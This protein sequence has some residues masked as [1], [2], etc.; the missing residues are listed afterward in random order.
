MSSAFPEMFM[1]F[2]GLRRHS[3]GE[4]DLLDTKPELDPSGYDIGMQGALAVW[5]LWREEIRGCSVRFG[6]PHG[7]LAGKVRG[8]V[9]I[10]CCGTVLRRAHKGK[11]WVVVWEL[12]SKGGIDSPVD[13]S[14]M[15]TG[16]DR[17]RWRVAIRWPG[18][19][20]F[21]LAAMHTTCIYQ[22]V[23]RGYQ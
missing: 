19:R 6:Y 14:D 7:V 11:V 3:T 1:R 13:M 9:I 23:S 17:Y 2:V 5:G 21:V 10:L 4:G 22:R 18:V 8:T 12:T 20:H 15:R 16:H